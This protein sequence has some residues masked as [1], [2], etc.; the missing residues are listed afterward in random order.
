MAGIS[1]SFGGVISAAAYLPTTCKIGRDW[2]AK[3]AIRKKT[4]K[5][6][7]NL[8]LIKAIRIFLWLV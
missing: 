8:K 7:E 5:I 4:T 3:A 6:Y 1:D 2:T